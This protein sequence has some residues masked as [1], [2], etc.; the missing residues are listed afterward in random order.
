LKKLV[1]VLLVAAM[2]MSFAGAAF[3]AD[4]SDTNDLSATAK[5]SIS[6]L[7]ALN[8]INGYPDGTF[9]PGNTITRA[10]FAKIACIIAGMEKSAEVLK[11]TPSKFTDVASGQWYTGYVNLSASQGYVKGFPDGTFRPNNQISYAEVVTVLLRIVGYNDNLPGPWPVD[12]IAKAAALD[13]TDDVSFDA[14]ADATRADVAVMSD[15]ALDCTVVS[16]DADKEKFVKEDYDLLDDSFEGSVVEDVYVTGWSYD[17]DDEEF[18]IDFSADIDGDDENESGA[19][20]G[21]DAQISGAALVKDLGKKYCD[22]IWNADDEEIVFIDVTST[23]VTAKESDIEKDGNDL[24][25]LDVTYDVADGYTVPELIE[26]VYYTVYLNEDDEVY[27][28]AANS[29]KQIAY[30]VDEYDEED[31]ILSAKNEGGEEWDLEDQ[32][33]LVAK[34]GKWVAL[35]DLVE[36]DVIYVNQD[37]NGVDYFIDVKAWKEGAFSRAYGTGA[38]YSDVKIAGT[39]YAVAA[40]ADISRDGGEEFDYAFNANGVDN[41]NGETVKYFLNK[42]YQVAF[43]MCDV[44]ASEDDELYGIIVDTVQDAVYDRVTGDTDWNN[45]KLTILLADGSKAT[46]ELSA[47]AKDADEDYFKDTAIVGSFVV[48]VLDEDGDILEIDDPEVTEDS[49]IITAVDEDREIIKVN[50]T[51]YYVTDKTV[52]FNTNPDDSDDDEDAIVEAT[53]VLYDA[54]TK[55]AII[56][57]NS[58][59]ELEYV[60][61]NVELSQTTDEYA[62]VTDT[63]YIDGNLWVDVDLR[64]EVKAYEVDGTVAS[65]TYMVFEYSFTG[66]KIEFGDNVNPLNLEGSSDADRLKQGA[67]NDYSISGNWVKVGDDKYFIDED[68]YIFDFTK[69]DPV[70]ATL[71]AIDKKADHAIIELTDDEDKNADVIKVLFIVK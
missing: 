33:V 3:A 1:T 19:V 67:L 57:A 51:W 20:V 4:F 34:N 68:T 66:S 38:T 44:E 46:Y 61:F 8:V 43:I 47:D 45:D 15:A 17:P 54:E 10:E 13:V 26:G 5:S 69:D 41:L 52:V 23:T 48:F 28:V 40:D 12:Y 22:I 55:N 16:W 27:R 36:N 42:A 60:V 32:D 30:V 9:K 2:V 14:S 70:Y 25:V 50:G 53:S 39:K 58:D 31:E 59:N 71:R 63:Y 56:V 29:N 64:G 11:N 35:T 18:S 37:T 21:K 62:L 24:E 49:E 6:K 7:N 65:E